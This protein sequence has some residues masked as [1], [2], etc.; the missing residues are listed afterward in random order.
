MPHQRAYNV[1]RPRT[2]SE[3]E[4]HDH[5]P[6]TTAPQYLRVFRTI[7]GMAASSPVSV[8]SRSATFEAA[9]NV[10]GI[11]VK[12][13]C[14]SLSGAATVSQEPGALVVEQLGV[15]LPIQTLTTG[16]KVREEHMRKY[17]FTRDIIGECSARP[18]AR[19]QT[20]R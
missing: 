17:I 2:E 18:P 4:K 9:S 14:T 5:N 12:G 11:E 1:L 20:L 19:A 13:T 10:P 16:M 15:L 8:E 3:G 7:A 6:N